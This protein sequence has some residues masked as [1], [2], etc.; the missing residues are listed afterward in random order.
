MK[1]VFSL[2]LVAM[3][4]LG[5]TGC[6]K[7][8]G[9]NAGDTEE[10]VKVAVIVPQKRGDLGFTDSIY[11]GVEEVKANLGEDVEI[12]FTEC[13]GDSS[14]FESTIYD[15]CDQEP[16]LIITPAGSG[17]ADL[18]A[19]KAAHD[20]ED[21][22]FVLVDASAA[23]TGITTDNVAAIS[24]KQNEATFLTGALSALLSETGTIGYVA[25]MQNAVINDFT[26]GYIQ[27]AQHINPDIKVLISYVG[28]FA[29]SAKAKELATTQIGL[30]ADVVAQVAGTAG[31]G[32]LD[33]AK[34]QSVWAIGVD[35]DQSKAYASSN[36]E[37][38]A[39]IASSAMKNGAKLLV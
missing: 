7:D 37:M 11:A 35:A 3:L 26:V 13:A 12:T 1:K 23:Y 22:N 27:G 30:G 24:Y 16:D 14:K 6:N 8:Q 29:D 31:L 18:I 36:P 9:G 2:F 5:L 33:A 39:R 32:V 19:T 38:S 25:G 28:D 4:A 15:T 20:Y 10:K 34:E 17:F 21:I